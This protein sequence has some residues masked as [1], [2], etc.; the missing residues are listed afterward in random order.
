[1]NCFGMGSWAVVVD[2]KSQYLEKVD[3]SVVGG[4][5]CGHMEYGCGKKK[6]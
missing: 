5:G 2:S 6:G 3:L 1:M 4:C